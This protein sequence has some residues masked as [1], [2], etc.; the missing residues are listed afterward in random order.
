[1]FINNNC[2]QSALADRF[3][4][5]VCLAILWRL[6]LFVIKSSVAPVQSAAIERSVNVPEEKRKY[7]AGSGEGVGRARGHVLPVSAALIDSLVGSGARHGT[8]GFHG[9][10]RAGGRSSLASNW[11]VGRRRRN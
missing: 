3:D 7:H 6:N 11:T 1:V 4:Y 2:I 5:F 10:L 8:Q 9:W